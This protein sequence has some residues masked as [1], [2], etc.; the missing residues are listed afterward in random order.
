MSNQQMDGS[1][2]ARSVR[3]LGRQ[4]NQTISGDGAVVCDNL[5]FLMPGSMAVR[6]GMVPVSFTGSVTAGTG[7]IIGLW[8]LFNGGKVTI[9]AQDSDGYIR[10]GTTPT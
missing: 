8:P 3:W 10:A 4:S 9:V 2:L 6:R 7:S 1:Q 5:Q